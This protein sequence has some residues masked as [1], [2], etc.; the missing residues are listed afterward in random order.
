MKPASSC[1]GERSRFGVAIDFDGFLG[2]VDDDP[3]LL[4]LHQMLFD[5]CP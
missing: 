5:R 3:A 4:A 2:G 1:I